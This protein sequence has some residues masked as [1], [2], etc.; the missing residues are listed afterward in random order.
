MVE[1]LQVSHF[2]WRRPDEK[3]VPRTRVT[4]KDAK[5]ELR[6]TI[7]EGTLRDRSEVERKVKLI[8]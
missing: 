6:S 5:G 7:L 4:W 1:I 3:V 2:T 8:R